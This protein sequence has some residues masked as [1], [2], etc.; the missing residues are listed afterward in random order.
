MYKVFFLLH[1]FKLKCIQIVYIISKIIRKRQLMNAYEVCIYTEVYIAHKKP[2]SIIIYLIFFSEIICDFS[3][4]MYSV[5]SF[6]FFKTQQLLAKIKYSFFICDLKLSE[7][8]LQ[9]NQL[10]YKYFE[11]MDVLNLLKKKKQSKFIYYYI[12]IKLKTILA[13]AHT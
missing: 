6:N 12:N 8:Y 7:S 3:P 2:V 9:N 1:T 11:I 4:H 13:E 5:K 10:D